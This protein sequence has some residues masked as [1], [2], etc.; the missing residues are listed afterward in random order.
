MKKQTYNIKTRIMSKNTSYI[1]IAKKLLVMTLVMGASL[2]IN[3]GTFAGGE[4]LFKKCAGCHK[5]SAKESTGPGLAGVTEKRTDEWII[6]WVHNSQEMVNAGD[7]DAVAVFEEFNNI[8]M[9]SYA[10]MTD[11]EILSIFAFIDEKNA[12]EAAGG[13][14]TA[15]VAASTDEKPLDLSINPYIAWGIVILI[16]L[17]GLYFVQFKKNVEKLELEHGVRPSPFSIKNYPMMLLLF[18]IAMLAIVYILN[19]LLVNNVGSS[20]ALLLGAFPYVALAIFLIGTIYRYTKKG[21]QVS[22]LSSQFLEGKKLFYGSQPFHWGLLVLFFGHLIAFAFPS[23][24]LAWNGQPI[25]LLILEVSSFAFALLALT[26]LILLIIRRITSKT[27]LMVTNKMDMVVYTILLVQILS[28]LGVAFFV[29]WGSTWFA[30]ALTPYLRSVFVFN[31][32]IS[33]ISEAPFLIQIHVISAFFLIAII[34]FTRFMHFLV[35]P[36]DYAWIGEKLK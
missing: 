3:N 8:P 16:V 32:D 7:A 22:S 2:F 27:L 34:P 12:A 19:V 15:A 10:D 26:G 24:V 1:S 30:S 14:D 20:R 25:R 28:G 4:D 18:I 29:R 23:A 33:V 35:A 6:N 13:G 21:Y 17:L 9:P 31:P 11:E 36:V 5:T